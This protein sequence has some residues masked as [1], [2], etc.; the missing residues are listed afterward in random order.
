MK[1]VADCTIKELE[2]ALTAGPVSEEF[3]M[4]QNSFLGQ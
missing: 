3:L 4:D 1:A 2:A